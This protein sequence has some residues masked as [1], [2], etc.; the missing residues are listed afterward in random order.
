MCKLLQTGKIKK[1][2]TF[3]HEEEQ[4]IFPNIN[5]FGMALESHR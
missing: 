3:Y 1:Q 4:I 5:A 2:T